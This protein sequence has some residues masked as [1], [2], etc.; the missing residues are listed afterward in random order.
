M[1]NLQE[2]LDAD[3]NSANPHSGYGQQYFT[4]TALVETCRRHCHNTNPASVIDPQAGDGALVNGYGWATAKFGIDIDS[5][6]APS[7]ALITSHC[8]KVWELLDE[9]FP[10][11]KFAVANANP[12]FGKRWKIGDKLVDSTLLTWNWVTKHAGSGFFIASKKT[13]EALELH[14]HPWVTKAMFFEN[15]WPNCDVVVTVLWWRNPDPMWTPTPVN[16]LRQRWLTVKKIID[17]E[18]A[19]RPKFNIYLNHAGYLCTYLSVKSEIQLKLDYEQIQR[20]HRINGQHPLT[21]TTERETRDLLSSLVNAGIYTVEPV[22]LQSINHALDEV[23]RVACPIMP[24]TDFETVAYADEEEALLCT[25][26][27]ETERLKFT[28]GKHY[29][30]DTATYTF[31]QQFT[32]KKVH[33]SEE[34]QTTYTSEHDCLLSGQDRMIRIKDDRGDHKEFMDRPDKDLSFQ[35]DESMLWKI[36]KKPEIKTVAEAVPDAIT[37]N[38]AVLKACEMTAGYTYYQGQRPYLARV[39]T[40]DFGLVAG[41]GGTGKSLMAITL[42]AMKAPERCLI[43][44]P[45]ATMRS[46]D[47]AEEEEDAFDYNVSQWLEEMT[48]FA[49]YLSVYELFSY[50]DY[51]RILSMHG[52]QLPPGVYVTYYEGLFLNN[53][54]ESAAASW[55]DTKLNKHMLALTGLTDEHALPETEAD[56]TYW[57]RSVGHEKNGI[58]CIISPCLAT[59]IGHHF[60]MVLL[61]EAH[62][63]CNLE[64]HQAQMLIRMQ[65]RYRYAFT[66]SPIPNL[67]TNLFSLCGWLAIPDWHKGGRRSA[68]WPYAREEVSRFN[69][70]FLSKERDFTQEKMNQRKDPKWSGKCEKVSPIISSPARLLKILKPLMAFIS[71]ADCSPDYKPAKVVDV[72]V[73]MGREQSKLYAYYLDRGHIPASHPLVRARKQTAWLRSICADPAGFR[74][75]NAATPKVHSNMNPKVIAILELTRDILAQGEQVVIIN[76]RIGITDTIQAKLVDAGVPIAR[77][78]STISAEQH[79]YQANIFKAGKARVMLM[80]IKCAASHSFDKCI[81]EIIGSI[82]YTPGTFNQAKWRVDRINSRPGVTIYCI[83]HQT[84]IEEVQFEVVATKDDAATICLRGKR[85]PKTYKPVDASEILATAIDRFDLTGSTPEPECEARWPK[86][87]DAIKGAI[88]KAL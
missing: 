78:D 40:K 21:L 66:A 70:T 81:Y 31:R 84:S 9:L 39:A 16:E 73:P 34:T 62:K 26:C 17:E 2:H 53:S 82:E 29:K 67:I 80:G 43:I 12:P 61:D 68:A 79:A 60:D 22:A 3:P 52:G 7:Y 54:R 6:L 74:H 20:L 32:R 87:R 8:V 75:G 42:L 38:L 57:C 46:S 49:P 47:E 63:V 19:A 50:S 11:T 59:L 76:S 45:Q 25:Q 72:R 30:V 65:P 48:K 4:P 24:V 35:F 1:E 41:E 56:P 86:L 33:F 69:A 44:A 5:R 51:E 77:I 27:I 37:Q 13:I 55:N 83:L 14:L 36:F 58:R 71:K 23:R 64:S 18:K 10:D 85:V 28:A 88:R 15:I